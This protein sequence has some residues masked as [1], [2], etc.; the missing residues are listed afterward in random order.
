MKL[1]YLVVIL[2]TLFA[3]AFWTGWRVQANTNDH[4]PPFTIHYRITFE[5]AAQPANNTIQRGVLARASD[6]SFYEQV[7]GANTTMTNTRTAQQTDFNVVLGRKSTYHISPVA[8]ERL[9]SVRSYSDCFDETL[10]FIGNDVIAGVGVKKYEVTKGDGSVALWLAPALG[11]QFLKQETVNTDTAGYVVSTYKREAVLVSRSEPDAAYFT[12]PATLKEVEPAELETALYQAS[13][14]TDA[15]VPAC[16]RNSAERA[17][18]RYR[19]GIGAN[20]LP[21]GAAIQPPQPR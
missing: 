3:G 18:E 1:K 14:G 11:C 4:V 6:G 16:V 13:H 7:E 9:M 20:G 15:P 2:T 10:K 21:E 5:D 19:K 8:V 12:V 17:N